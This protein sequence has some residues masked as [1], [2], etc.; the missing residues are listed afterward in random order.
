[1]CR[2]IPSAYFERSDTPAEN[3][4][5]GKLMQKIHAAFPDMD[6]QVI[7][8]EAPESL[9]GVGGVNRIQV[10]FN[11]FLRARKLDKA[12]RT[13]RGEAIPAAQ[14]P[15]TPVFPLSRLQSTAR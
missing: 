2:V 3:S 10:A 6:L 5:V 15:E 9:C 1:M 11:L 7:R 8:A 14:G 13:T 4:P 12:R